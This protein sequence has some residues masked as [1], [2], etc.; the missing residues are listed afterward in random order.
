MN[1]CSPRGVACLAAIIA[2]YHAVP[3]SAATSADAKKLSVATY[4]C[5]SLA[6]LVS[7]DAALNM[8]PN[9][10]ELLMAEA[11]ALMKHR[12]PGEAIGVYRNALKWG[13]SAELVGTDIAAAQVQRKVMVDACQSNAGETGERA[14]EGAWLPG[15]PD[16][17]ALFKRR[18]LLLRE[19]HHADEALSAYMAAARLAPQD[20]N[21]ARAVLDLSAGHRYD[22]ATLLAR[23]SALLTLSRPAEAS[24]EFKRALRLAPNLAEAK[25]RLRI[26]ERAIPPQAAGNSAGGGDIG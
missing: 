24:V 17:V 21:V 1:R 14:C 11:D 8:R 7:C 13:A 9:D 25:L 22:A 19:L 16:E 2:V 6:E 20:R 15:A 12:R 23:G 26:A 5:R 3:A 18:G 4:R 10:P